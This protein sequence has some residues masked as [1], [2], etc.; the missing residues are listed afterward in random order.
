MDFRT[1]TSLILLSIVVPGVAAG[2]SMVNPDISAVADM[3]YVY[4]DDV[5]AA[6]AS[7]NNGSFEFEELELAFIG[8]L[9]PYMRADFFLGIHGVTG[10][11]E[12]EE[13][14][15]SVVRGLP[16]QLR[17]GKY[18]LDFGKL[19]TQHPHQWGWLERPLMYRTVFG[20]DGASV[21]GAGASRL[22][23]LGDN[24]VTL[25]VS[26]F[27][28]DFFE[29]HHHE[30]GEEGEE[31][32]HGGEGP[33]DIGGSGRLSFF[34]SLTENT[35]LE[36][37]GSGLAARYDT[38]HGLDTWLVGGDLKLRWRPDT[39][40]SFNLVAEGLYSEREVKHE[41][42][43][44]VEDVTAWGAF[45][46]AEF[47]FRKR[48]DVG[49]FADWTQDAYVQD[50]ETT[51]LGGY[52]GFMPVEETARFSLVYRHEASDFYEGESDSVTLQVLWSLGPHKPHP[53]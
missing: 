26:A 33:A 8:Y 3:R 51:A 2:Q 13:G 50:A 19:N 15:A 24:A 6:L 4:R 7:Q 29:V 11:F 31:H 47:R 41:E 5:A 36:I 38:E 1:L 16:V 30:E 35:H 44:P 27:R 20:T 23:G 25:S 52:L 48:Y 9:N 37:G 22:Q 42:V 10:P 34:R 21:I 18:L 53:F 28:S 12:L 17:F 39:Y 45:S 43:D 32:E 40:R 14:Y 49:A 46:S